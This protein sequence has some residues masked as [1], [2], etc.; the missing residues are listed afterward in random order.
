MRL[1][2][3]RCGEKA[4]IPDRVI[5][6][7]SNERSTFIEKS[8]GPDGEERRGVKSGMKKNLV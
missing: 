5:A 7:L 6:S 1:N 8:P 3:L 2:P 4:S